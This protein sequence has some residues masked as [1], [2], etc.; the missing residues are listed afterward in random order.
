MTLSAMKAAL[1]KLDANVNS[2]GRAASKDPRGV[3]VSPN[4]L[5]ARYKHE[6]VTN[7]PVICTGCGYSLTAVG[8]C[9]KCGDSARELA[10]AF[11]KPPHLDDLM[12]KHAVKGK[13]QAKFQR[14]GH[15]SGK[16]SAA[17]RAMKPRV[18][19]DPARKHKAKGKP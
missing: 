8:P 18:V 12:E 3:M 4:E 5:K 11:V 1:A 16:A 10:T 6:G 14:A 9:P 7:S 17:V 2:D 13:P 15:V 19:P